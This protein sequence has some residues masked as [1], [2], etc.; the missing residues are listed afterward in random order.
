MLTLSAWPL[1]HGPGGLII[2]AMARSRR[3]RTTEPL[4]QR[5]I[6]AA[7]RLRDT[8]NDVIETVPV[9]VRKPAEFQRVL[10]LDR[11]LASR[12]LRA[13]QMHDPLASLH[14]MPGPHGIR[15]LLRAAGKAGGDREVIAGAEEALVAVEHLIAAELGDWK[16]LD[17]A[18]SGWLPDAREQF[19]MANRQA[20][21]RAMSNI[22]GVTADAEVS[23]T[24]IHP[25]SAKAN[26]V[27]RAGITGICRMKRL[28]PGTPMGLLHGSSIAPPP[29][30]Q[31][32]S[33]DGQPI[34]PTHGAPLLREFS[35]SPTPRF[36]VRVEGDLVHYVLEGDDV[37]LGSMVDLLFA[38]VMR[39]RYPEHKGISPRPATPG[40]VIDIPVKVLIVDVLVHEDVWPGVEPELRM[41]DTAV[42]G[43]ANPTDP[44]RN[45]DRIDVL[46]SIQDI[47]TQMER[48]RAKEVARYVDMV[49]FVCDKLGWQG[50]RFRGF[51]C[52]VD[53]PVYGTQVSMMFEPPEPGNTG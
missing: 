14:R 33:L 15:L 4:Q 37:G 10:K 39:G 53:Y 16:E 22:K 30:T 7:D 40:A 49:Q 2:A 19:E 36:E 8:V 20:A 46:E 5:L 51:R 38:D 21:F 24:L 45:M 23:V 44:S 25:G 26:W 34:D 35:S 31:R 17:A 42:L 9:P 12:L 11:S 50:D 18:I 6:Q 28:R 29:G 27:D 47:G 13:V 43:I 3:P 52:R 41:Y 32:L 48:F 1:Q